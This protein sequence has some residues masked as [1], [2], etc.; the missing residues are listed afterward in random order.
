MIRL[1]RDCRQAGN[2][3]PTCSSIRVLDLK[4]DFNP[5]VLAD[6]SESAGFGRCVRR[7]ISAFTVMRVD[8]VKDAQSVLNLPTPLKAFDEPGKQR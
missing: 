5:R 2:Q 8:V 7:S 6:G 4:V 1:Q 3:R